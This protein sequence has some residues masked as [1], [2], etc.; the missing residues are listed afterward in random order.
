M[1]CR[2]L[3]C[4]ILVLAEEEGFE[5]NRNLLTLSKLCLPVYFSYLFVNLSVIETIFDDSLLILIR[6]QTICR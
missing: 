2:L 5:P 3:S 4:L 1:I 6:I